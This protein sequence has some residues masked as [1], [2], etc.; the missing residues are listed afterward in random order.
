MN[1]QIVRALGLAG[2]MLGGAVVLTLAKRAGYIDEDLTLRGIMVLIG[3]M[4]IVYAND[5]PKAV[6]KKT[7][8]GQAMQ[9]VAARALV[10]AYLAYVAVWIF[11]PMSLANGLAMIPVALAAGWIAV[12]CLI[13]RTRT[14]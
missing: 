13:S 9:R 14:A 4:M 5:I 10:L 1:K 7:A 8:R 12:A 2:V 6:I 3:L 11:A